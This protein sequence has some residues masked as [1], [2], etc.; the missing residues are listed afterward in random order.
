[1]ADVAVVADLANANANA[2]VNEDNSIFIADDSAIVESY[3]WN[4]SIKY[5]KL[6]DRYIFECQI[7]SDQ[8]PMYSS[9]VEINQINIIQSYT[10]RCKNRKYF[11][12]S[13][14]VKLQLPGCFGQFIYRSPIELTKQPFVNCYEAMNTLF[15]TNFRHPSV[16]DW[17]QG[18]IFK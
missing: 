5:N 9:I 10:R 17:R 18:H 3:I 11:L 13:G 1:M 14:V 7:L 8:F 16:E 15:D 2:N 6:T 12:N 4:M